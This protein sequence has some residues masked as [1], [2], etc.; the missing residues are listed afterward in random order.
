MP[1]SGRVGL[2]IARIMRE[3]KNEQACS[4]G[5]CETCFRRAALCLADHVAKRRYEQRRSYSRSDP[6]ERRYVH[7]QL[8]MLLAMTGVTEEDIYPEEERKRS[9]W[10]KAMRSRQ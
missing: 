1:R 5:C 2:D 3:M 6:E 8:R 9:A 7:G 4:C 10:G